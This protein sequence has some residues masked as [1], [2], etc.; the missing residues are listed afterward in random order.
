[1]AF[2]SSFTPA[3]KPASA[4]S[5]G[6]KAVSTVR[7]RTSP[8]VAPRTP[9]VMKVDVTEKVR[10]SNSTFRNL[11]ENRIAKEQSFFEPQRGFAPNAEKVNGR[12][13]MIGFTLGLVTELITGKGIL[14]QVNTLFEPLSKL[15]H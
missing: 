12:Y 5:F 8:T 2:V 9:V 11:E 13:A 1:M 14:A 6:N 3:V 7:H 15:L 10:K 4:A